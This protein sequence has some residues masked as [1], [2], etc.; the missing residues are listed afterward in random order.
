MIVLGSISSFTLPKESKFISGGFQILVAAFPSDFL[1]PVDWPFFDFFF[2][3]I[4]S[5]YIIGN[6]SVPFT[7]NKLY[8]YYAYIL[9]V[10]IYTY[11][12]H[13]K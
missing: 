1:Q 2:F 9:N 12:L 3:L 7:E 10:Q 13:I 8:V 6:F 5:N 11:V 4:Y